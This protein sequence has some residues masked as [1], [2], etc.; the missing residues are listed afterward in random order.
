MAQFGMGMREVVVDGFGG[1]ERLGVATVDVPRPGAGEALLR[2]IAAG[3][4][5]WDGKQRRGEL[6]PQPF[7]YIPG[8]EASGVIAALGEGV[9][10]LAVG[11]EVM[12]YRYPGGAW[13]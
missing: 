5:Q 10:D 8:W 6:G 1:P 9:V 11:D 3:M 12:T 13:A 7:P 4:G 2:V